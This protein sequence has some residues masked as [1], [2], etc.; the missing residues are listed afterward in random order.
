MTIT[1][2][3]QKLQDMY[4]AD[5]ALLQDNDKLDW[6]VIHKMRRE[7]GEV[8]KQIVAE[9][10]W[11]DIPRFGRES[12]SAWLLVQHMDHDLDFQKQCLDL[13]LQLP[14]ASVARHDIVWLTD[15]IMMKEEGMQLYGTQ[16]MV[17]KKGDYLMPLKD[18]E[19]VDEHRIK[20][21]L[22]PIREMLAE[23]TER[24]AYIS[25]EEY[26]QATGEEVYKGRITFGNY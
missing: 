6:D 7:Q 13:M 1:E 16:F 14:E 18:I 5:Q 24:P 23:H 19:H 12:N 25:A 11:I 20:M 21:G 22:K 3:K 9:V 17:G 2:I 26:E 4:D 8:M 10:G 15:R